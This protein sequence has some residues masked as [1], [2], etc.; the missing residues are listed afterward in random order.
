MVVVFLRSLCCPTE[1]NFLFSCPGRPR[2]DV[3]TKQYPSGAHAL[4]SGT[5][6]A[7][8]LYRVDVELDTYMDVQ[9]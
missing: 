1:L 5:G 6:Q 9:P 3:I 7:S 4:L 8:M 2:G